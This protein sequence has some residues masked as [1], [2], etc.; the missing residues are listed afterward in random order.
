[1]NDEQDLSMVVTV[2][3]Y[4]DFLEN[5]FPKISDLLSKSNYYTTKKKIEKLEYKRA[6]QMF[7]NL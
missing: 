7:S 1:M 3:E 5:H 4:N 2:N 6:K